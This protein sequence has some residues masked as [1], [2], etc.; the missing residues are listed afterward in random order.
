MLGIGQ[1]SQVLK[2]HIAQHDADLDPLS[3]YGNLNSAVALTALGRA[4]EASAAIG[5]AGVIEPDALWVPVH[6]TFMEAASGSMRAAA[7]DAEELVA[8]DRVKTMPP[9]VARILDLI[10]A[11]ARGDRPEISRAVLRVREPAHE[12]RATLIEVQYLTAV[13]IPML[14]RAG[15]ADAALGILADLTAADS[16]PPYDMVVMNPFLKRLMED[17][18]AREIVARSR[19]RFDLLLEAIEEARSGG[20][21]PRYLEQPLQDLMLSLRDS[22]RAR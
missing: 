14:A 8:H 21:F 22:G 3:A 17:A 1:F 7:A 6:R 13:A 2:L 16:P 5:R 11:D 12:G 15:Q 18:R 19:A 20:R 10:R 4:D 9:F